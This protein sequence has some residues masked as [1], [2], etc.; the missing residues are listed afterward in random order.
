MGFDFFAFEDALLGGV[1]GF[2]GRLVGEVGEVVG[3]RVQ[4]GHEGEGGWVFVIIIIKGGG[5]I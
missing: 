1:L 3:E 4:E 2:E 5:D